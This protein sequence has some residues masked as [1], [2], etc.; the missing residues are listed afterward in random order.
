MTDAPVEMETE[1]AEESAGI[2]CSVCGHNTWKVTRTR[3]GM[4]TI[5]RWRTCLNPKCRRKIRTAERVEAET[6][7]DH[8]AA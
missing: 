2:V 8:D 6:H 1:T 7:P 5:R 3:L 4:G